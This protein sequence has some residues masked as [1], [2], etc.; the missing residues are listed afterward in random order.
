MPTDLAPAAPADPNNPN[1]GPGLPGYGDTKP[2]PFDA[3]G[4]FFMDMFGAFNRA[5]SAT[6]LL[7]STSPMSAR[8]LDPTLP[9]W[10]STDDKAPN[11][12][13][14]PSAPQYWYAGSNPSAGLADD[15]VYMG[16]EVQGPRSHIGM[17][18]QPGDDSIGM[19]GE[20]SLHGSTTVQA[21]MNQPYLWD[22]K[23]V[24]EVQ[25]KMREAGLNVNSF[26]EMMQ[27]WGGLVQHASRVFTL[28]AGKTAVTPWDMLDQTKQEN[29]AAG[30]L[31]A[32]GNITKTST[33]TSIMD[34]SEGDAWATMKNATAQL[35]GRDPTDQ[36][37][38]DFA[39]RASNV[40][41]NHP[42]TTTSTMTMNAET[43]DQSTSS[44]SSQGFDSNDL[45]HMAY[46]TAQGNPDY[47]AYQAATTYTNAML[48][49]LGEVAPG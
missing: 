14:S 19:Q 4:N 47:G 49:A 5:L 29:I 8:T 22:Q 34:V 2:P 17:N 15:R 20:T 45:A 21:A 28:S 46:N 33:H 24:L 16:K 48:G 25:K 31:D 7:P 10:V 35:L 40:A 44:T 26:D 42:T 36:E 43:G 38:R 23:K 27:A 37:I 1:Y 41:A 12:Y 18:P 6:G 3:G 32:D 13:G 11:G 39:S 9:P 30:K